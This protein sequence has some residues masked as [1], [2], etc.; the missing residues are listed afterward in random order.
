MRLENSI[1]YWLLGSALN[2]YQSIGYSYVEAPWRVPV[3]IANLTCSDASKHETSSTGLIL[4][5][6]AEQ[7][8][9]NMSYHALL[10]HDTPLVACGPCFRLNEPDTQYHQDHFMKVELGYWCENTSH[11]SV[12][13]KMIRDAQAFM[14]NYSMSPVEIIETP[15][16]FDLEIMGVE[17]GSYGYR[18]EL[19]WV[20]G[21]GIALPRF[22]MVNAKSGD[23]PSQDLF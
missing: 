23:I 4:A 9:I 10:P 22:N 2:H 5:G 8:L 19:K 15:E 20:F 16:G 18:P 1:N 11:E 14:Q 13:E 17:V 6:S 7:G 21:T 12:M 3:K